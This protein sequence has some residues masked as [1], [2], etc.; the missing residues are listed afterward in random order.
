MFPDSD[1]IYFSTQ[2]LGVIELHN[3]ELISFL[4]R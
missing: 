4:L 2:F 3:A 1:S